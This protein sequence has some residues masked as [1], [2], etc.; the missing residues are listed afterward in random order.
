MRKVMAEAVFVGPLLPIGIALAIK[1]A[2]DLVSQA[3][4]LLE[5]FTALLSAIKEAI[6]AADRLFQQAC[7]TLR[8]LVVRLQA[9]PH[10]SAPAAGASTSGPAGL[11]EGARRAITRKEDAEAA[12]R[13]TA[14]ERHLPRQELRNPSDVSTAHE[15]QLN[16]SGSRFSLDDHAATANYWTRLISDNSGY[17]YPMRPA[18]EPL[19]PELSQDGRPAEQKSRRRK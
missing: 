11:D 4:Q 12:A 10:P 3:K 8:G 5:E 18:P 7:A 2:W 17:Q 13:R 19:R 1:E 15:R 9:G 16:D 6:N 14:K